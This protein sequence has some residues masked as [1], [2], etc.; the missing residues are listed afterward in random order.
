MSKH[1]AMS[2]PSAYQ[3]QQ[4]KLNYSPVMNNNTKQTKF[5]QKKNNLMGNAS[6]VNQSGSG[7]G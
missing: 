1:L 4:R 6:Q 7:P 2:G 5:T 3:H